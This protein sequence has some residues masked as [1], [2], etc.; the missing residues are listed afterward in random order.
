ME[1]VEGGNV[2][3]E[4]L[5]G[6]IEVVIDEDLLEEGGVGLEEGELLLAGV[7]PGQDLVLGLSSTATKALL[8]DLSGNWADEH[9]AGVQLGDLGNAE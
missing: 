2:L 5:V 9:E 3:L 4:L 8:Q 1:G 7:E 6:S